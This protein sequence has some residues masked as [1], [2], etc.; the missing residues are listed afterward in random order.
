MGRRRGGAGQSVSTRSSNPS[1][2]PLSLFCPTQ[3]TTN[4]ATHPRNP[5]QRHL[6]PTLGVRAGTDDL[7]PTPPST[8]LLQQSCP[9]NN[10]VFLGAVSQ[11]HKWTS[12]LSHLVYR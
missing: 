9:R 3:K 10:R 12:R 4:H 1:I 8:T 11:P 5:T 6:E 7:T 2:H